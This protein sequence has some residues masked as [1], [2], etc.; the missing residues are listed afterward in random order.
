MTEGHV[1]G[2]VPNEKCIVCFQD[3]DNGEKTFHISV[4]GS[5][6]FNLASVA[7]ETPS[8]KVLPEQ[9]LHSACRRNHTD[10]KR[11]DI[12]I[13]KRKSDSS[14]DDL[15][16]PVLRSKEPQFRFRDHCFLCGT[17][18]VPTDGD[19]FQV[20]TWDLQRSIVK[21]CDER[22]DD[23]SWAEAVRARL[24]F[25]RDLP[26]VD[27]VYHQ[28]CSVNFRTGKQLPLRY[29]THDHGKSIK[30]PKMGRRQDL[31]REEAFL[32]V[33]DDLREN[34]DERTTVSDLVEKMLFITPTP[35]S[36]KY[37]RQKLEQH[38]GDAIVITNINGG[39][40]VVTYRTTAAN[41]LQDFYDAPKL[42]D[43]A[44]HYRS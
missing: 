18:A 30:V 21:A 14:V 16:P 17:D 15:S 41:I 28:V 24:I 39:H 8:V 9:R 35:Y 12:L 25:G 32:L 36:A 26:A 1:D 38:L 43:E 11:I 7:R 2:D 6:S 29:R 34:D 20:R 40:D 44:T 5:V 23:D 4:K 13:K 22:K 42:D 27:A 3:L 37:M 19:V 10:K 31:S 33:V